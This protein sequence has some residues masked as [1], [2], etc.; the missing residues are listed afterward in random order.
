MTVRHRA[1]PRTPQEA[2]ALLRE[3]NRAYTQQSPPQP[4][5][6]QQR[7]LQLATQGQQPYAVV[8]TCSDSRVP[9]EHLFSTGLGDLFVIRTAGN[10][11]GPF[12]LGSVEYGAEHLGA[13]VIVVL[14]HSGCGAVSAALDG[15]AE[16]SIAAIIQEINAGRGGAEHPREAE[17]RNILHS[18][19][20][21]R[22][23]DIVRRLEQQGH[24]LVVGAKYDLHSGEV[25]FFEES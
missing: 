3:G 13:K 19:K 16:G 21:V 25:R 15:H 2:I 23:S 5:L 24:L 14:G 9:P 6:S 12:A 22:E 18:I 4:D 7:R 1:A 8:V 10:V 11:V 17:D 20:R